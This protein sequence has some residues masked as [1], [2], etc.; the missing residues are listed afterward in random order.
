MT[1]NA[2]APAAAPHWA[3]PLGLNPDQRGFVVTKGLK[4]PGALVDSLIG[5]ERAIGSDKIALPPKGADGKRDWSK[6]DGFGELGRPA[7]PDAYDLA[8]VKMPEGVA[9]K[10]FN[11]DALK[12][13]LGRMHARGASQDQI[14]EAMGF[15]GE[16]VGGLMAAQ[17]QATEAR[18]IAA[19][20]AIRAQHGAAYDKNAAL[21]KNALRAF[22]GDKLTASLKA[23]NLLAPD[24]AVLDP[25]IFGFLA[26]VGGKLAGDLDN[27]GA[28]D[29]VPGVST[30]ATAQADHAKMMSETFAAQIAGT[31]HPGW[32]R[33]HPEF[34]LYQEK[35][36]RTL[37]QAWPEG[38]PEDGKKPGRAAA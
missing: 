29:G 3:D 30:P 32:D 13:F 8:G 37:A 7:T 36:Q 19:H 25:T 12:G 22:G 2:P 17:T 31:S 27:P 1:E 26:E 11:Q 34:K 35:V 16:Y 28:K 21:A 4:D 33:N 5:A 6:W 24:G 20:E 9:L 15:Y 10:D 18:A 14:A 23:A 38:Q